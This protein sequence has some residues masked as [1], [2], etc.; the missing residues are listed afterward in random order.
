LCIFAARDNGTSP[1]Q[2]SLEAF[3]GIP[4]RIFLAVP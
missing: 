3:Q 4:P 2:Y 1:W